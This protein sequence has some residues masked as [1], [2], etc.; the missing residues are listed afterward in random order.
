MI[1][2]RRCFLTV[3]LY[4][5]FDSRRSVYPSDY[6]VYL[7]EKC[8]QRSREGIGSAAFNFVIGFVVVDVCNLIVVG[9]VASLADVKVFSFS[10][11]WS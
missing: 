2:L 1:Y 11:A 6:N 4:G 7:A 5:V 9:A 10:G 3:C 8:R